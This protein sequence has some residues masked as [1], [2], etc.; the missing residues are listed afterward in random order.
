MS[1]SIGNYPDKLKLVKVIP[2]HKGG[3]TQDLNNF[4]PISLSMF[5][6]IIE[7]IIHLRLYALLETHNI[8]YEKQFGFRKNNST[9]FALIQITEKIKESI[10][11]RK[12]GCG[13]IIDLR[14]V[15]E[16]V[17]HDIL[18]FMTHYLTRTPLQR[19]IK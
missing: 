5:G 14:K 9:I 11:K 12:F 2:I 1:L 7:K 15:F 17:S 13:I 19:N 16:T 6:K 4:R 10:D 8:L 18:F 3:S